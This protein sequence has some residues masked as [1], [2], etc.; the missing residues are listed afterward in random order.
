MLVHTLKHLGAQHAERLGR[1]RRPTTAENATRLEPGGVR[2]E[3]ARLRVGKTARQVYG[4]VPLDPSLLGRGTLGA[5][6]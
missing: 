4:Q 3:H 6:R 1:G 5:A 2:S